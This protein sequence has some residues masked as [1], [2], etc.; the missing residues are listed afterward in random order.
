MTTQTAHARSF[1]RY[2]TMSDRDLLE[3]AHIYGINPAMAIAI[4]ERLD[5]CCG[6]PARRH[7]FKFNT[8]EGAQNT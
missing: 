4:A 3:E 7:H 8:N 6:D 5:T 1:G 2:D